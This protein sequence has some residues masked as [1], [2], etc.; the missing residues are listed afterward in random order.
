M[1][2]PN[3]IAKDN[4][5]SS[6]KG[7]ADF[8][9]WPLQADRAS[10]GDPLVACLQII[11]GH[12]GRRTSRESLTAG[13]PLPKTGI[14]P[15]LMVR[16]AERADLDIKL[17]DRALEGIAIAPS[18]PCILVLEQGQACILWGVLYADKKP[19][20]GDKTEFSV[21]FPETASEKRIISLED[22]KKIYTGY[23][24]YVRPVARV[25]D[26][27]GPA[28]IDNAKDW[29]WSTIWQNRKIYYE[30]GLAALMINL[31]AIAMPLYT[32]NIYDRVV[33]NAAYETLAVLSIGLAVVL[34][35]DL[36]IKSLRAHFLDYAGRKSDV[37]LSGKLFEQLLGMTM[38]S[39]PAS[40]GVLAANMREFES[41]R[42]F[43]TSATLAALI[44]LPFCLLFIL[45][46]A[47][48]AGPLAIIPLVA[49]P[50]IIG[51]GWVLQKPM[52]KITQES[53]HENALKNALLFE[54]I[55]GLETIKTQASEGH[56]QR[57][58]EELCEKSSRTS[59]KS[60]RVSNFALNISYFLQNMV[61][62]A[63]VGFGVVL[64]SNAHITMGALI[65][66]VM[67]SSRALAPLTQFSGLMIRFNQTRESLRQLNELMEKPVERP[68][69]KTFIAMPAIQGQLVFKDVVF[70]Y[71]GSSVPALNHVS[72][73]IQAG[74]HI[75]I[76]GAVGSGKTTLE[77]LILNKFEPQ[78]GSVQ[79]DGTDVR[80][81]DPGDLRRNIGVVQQTPQL[82]YGSVRENIT[83]GHETA[84]D[85]AVV[86]AAELSGVM[87]FLKDSSHG[88]DTQ[89]GE[90][91]EQL[92]GGQRQAIA[93]AR[94]LLYD[95]P[96]IILD[97]PTAS[98][99]P[100]SESRLKGHLEKL[101]NGKTTILITHK[102]S[103]LSLVDKIIL[104]DRGKILAFGPRDEIIRQLQ[105]RDYAGSDKA[106]A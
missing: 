32:M 69:G 13:L 106:G 26:R 15:A 62:I 92:S 20:P 28:R 10:L 105:N 104:M 18:T 40:A 2:E 60:K 12:F 31:F 4:K 76:I 81:I 68:V 38:S 30:V 90:R 102:G 96:V 49:V 73:E 65:A 72:F 95:P 53:L 50:L 70:A 14:S 1:S 56:V 25:D 82:F 34:F 21:Q 67:L 88:L 89:V 57:R 36:V 83:M 52:K 42:D 93:I 11:A 103:M 22:L 29:F 74:E 100:A 84:S 19:A 91:G 61:T 33:P 63:I 41:I 94:A 39:R 8:D 66:T 47:V 51:T 58:W 85:R 24:F 55:T 37:K 9:P 46:I 64:I 45:L 101:T 17:V 97:E 23:A 78:S 99:D 59:V 7:V 44:D 48:I 77:R 79:L 35:F 16:A 71:P 54:T 6:V 27:A 5:I 87:D 43:F 86:R 75:G 98:M 3:S 80:Q